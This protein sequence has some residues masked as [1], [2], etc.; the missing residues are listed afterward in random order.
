LEVAVIRNYVIECLILDFADAIRNNGLGRPTSITQLW[1]T[2]QE[3]CGDCS[4]DEVLDALYNI[5]PVHASIVKW[6]SQGSEFQSVNFD[7]VRNTPSWQDFLMVG[8][9]NIKLLPAGRR[10][11]QTLSEH[12]MAQLPPFE[13]PRRPIGFVTR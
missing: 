6:T 7:E 9:F 10:Q 4:M 11:L 3:K 2:V 13:P 12:L 1:L 8:Y 5:Q